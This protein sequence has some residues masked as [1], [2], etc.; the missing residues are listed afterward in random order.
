[1]MQFQRCFF[2]SCI[3]LDDGKCCV[4]CCACVLRAQRE[5]IKCKFFSSRVCLIHHSC[6]DVR[7]A[8]FFCAEIFHSID[9]RLMEKNGWSLACLDVILRCG[10]NSKSLLIKSIKSSRASPLKCFSM[11]LRMIPVFPTAL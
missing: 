2:V 8:V 1:M 7:R 10:S 6:C 5:R 11:T 4:R 3:L 9:S